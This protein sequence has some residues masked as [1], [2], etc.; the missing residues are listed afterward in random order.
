MEG[1]RVSPVFT[2]LFILFTSIFNSEVFLIWILSFVN[3]LCER[4]GGEEISGDGGGG[5]DVVDAAV[6]AAEEGTAIEVAEHEQE[7][8]SRRCDGGGDGSGGEGGEAVADAAVK[9]VER[10]GTSA[11]QKETTINHW[12]GNAGGIPTFMQAAAIIFTLCKKICAV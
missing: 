12:C 11:R 6:K 9:E 8:A 5:Y 3:R 10:D 7:A 4:R 1:E 2:S